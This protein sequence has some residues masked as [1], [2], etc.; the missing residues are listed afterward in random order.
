VRI[1]GNDVLPNLD[2]MSALTW[3]TGAWLDI[4]SNAS[5]D[6]LDGLGNLIQ[7]NGDLLIYDNPDLP[8]CEACDLLD[9]LTLGPSSTDVYDNL[10]DTCTPVPDNCP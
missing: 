3:V 2:G 6:N 5:L 4:N 8:E 10:S 7:L 1:E 9:Q